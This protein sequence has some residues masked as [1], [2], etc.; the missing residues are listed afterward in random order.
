MDSCGFTGVVVGASTYCSSQYLQS[1]EAHI[2]RYVGP[3]AVNKL[4]DGNKAKV[5]QEGENVEHEQPLEEHEVGE[6]AGAKRATDLFHDALP[7]LQ[8]LPG[9][10]YTISAPAERLCSIHT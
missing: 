1:S 10:S 3:G 4:R 8:G 2:R 9:R 6:H 5:H 7:Q